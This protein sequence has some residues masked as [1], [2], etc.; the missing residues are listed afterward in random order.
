MHYLH[1]HMAP[2]SLEQLLFLLCNREYWN[3]SKVI[4]EAIYWDVE[5]TRA[6]RSA[7]EAAAAAARAADDLDDEDA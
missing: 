1:A 3:N 4:D 5:R 2:E 7:K 6:R